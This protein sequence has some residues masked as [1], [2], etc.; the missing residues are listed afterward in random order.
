[1]GPG[2]RVGGGVG[3]RLGGVAGLG[4]DHDRVA[5]ERRRGGRLGELLRELA[6]DEVQGALAH[7]PGGGGL[8]EGGGAAVAERD[9][10]A[11]G[12]AEELGEAARAP[13]RP[14]P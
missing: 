2:D 13:G 12:Q 6:V 10:V 7:E 14:G 4:L 1:M 3:G 8:P 5:E 9:L 11:V